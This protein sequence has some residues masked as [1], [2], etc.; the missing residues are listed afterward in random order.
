MVARWQWQTRLLYSF[1]FTFNRKFWQ[2]FSWCVI[3]IEGLVCPF[4]NYFLWFVVYF[5]VCV[6]VWFYCSC[7][8]G[9]HCN[10][11]AL[12]LADALNQ[13]FSPGNVILCLAQV[14]NSCFPTGLGVVR[15]W[16]PKRKPRFS[17]QMMG[18]WTLRQ[19][20]NPYPEL[21][22]TDSAD[23]LAD[24]QAPKYALGFSNMSTFS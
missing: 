12:R 16:L 2:V 3:G 18:E 10:L 14:L 13:Y 23:K 9:E 4:L 11:L 19:G 5:C 17:Y 21:Q 22:W 20:K 15:G 6:C 24:C 7:W 1:R 8:G